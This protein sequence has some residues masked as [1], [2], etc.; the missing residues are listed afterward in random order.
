MDTIPDSIRGACYT[1][2]TIGWPDSSQWPGSLW[3]SLQADKDMRN[4]LKYLENNDINGH[5]IG[6]SVDILLSNSLITSGKMYHESHLVIVVPIVKSARIKMP[7]DVLIDLPMLLVI[8]CIFHSIAYIFILS[9]SEWKAIYIFQN[10][11][12]MYVSFITFCEIINYV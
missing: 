1:V 2:R 12:S 5:M 4:I 7:M 3:Q 11:V 10:L 6:I 8:I 9:Q